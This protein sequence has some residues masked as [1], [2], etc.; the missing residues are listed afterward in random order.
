MHTI[1]ISP[2]KLRKARQW[3]TNA[4]NPS[5]LTQRELLRLFFEQAGFEPHF[6]LMGRFMLSLG[7]LFIPAARETVEM[8]YEFKKSYTVKADKLIHAFG[9]I[10]KPHYQAIKETIVWNQKFRGPEQPALP[11]DHFKRL[12]QN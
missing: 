5:N 3:Y 7:G 11:A 8:L 10:A 6:R 1:R 4:P 2:A 9:D 12:P